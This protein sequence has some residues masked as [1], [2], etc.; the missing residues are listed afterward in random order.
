M[1]DFIVTIFLDAYKVKNFKNKWMSAQT[2]AAIIVKHFT[3][4]P[5]L[6]FDGTC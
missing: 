5:D 3:V 1:S 2:W 6:Q 4:A